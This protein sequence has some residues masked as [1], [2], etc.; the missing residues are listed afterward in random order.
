MKLV[1]V[2]INI[3]SNENGDKH[4]II[5]TLPTS[6]INNN[7]LCVLVHLYELQIANCKLHT[8]HSIDINRLHSSL[9]KENNAKQHTYTVSARVPTTY[10]SYFLTWISFSFL[11]FKKKSIS[12][13]KQ[14]SAQ[15]AYSHIF[16]CSLHQFCEI[17]NL[18]VAKRIIESL[19]YWRGRERDGGREME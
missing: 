19:W 17:S 12:M 10:S 6:H 15:F 11:L 9:R 1:C 5:C 2:L 4:E 14:V 16:H 8:L 7:T 13:M 3:E 18:F